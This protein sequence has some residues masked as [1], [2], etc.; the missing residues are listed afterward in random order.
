VPADDSV[1]LAID[2]GADGIEHNAPLRSQDEQ[3]LK[4]MAQKGIS[5]MAGAGAFYIQRIDSTGFIDVIDPAQRRLFPED[6]LSAI[7]DGID[8]LHK[9]TFQ[10]K[11]AGWDAKQRQARFVS[12]MQRAR[13]AGVLLVFG[14]DCG[15]YGAIHGE[16]YK[17]LYGES[18]M[19]SSPM[20]AIVM[21]T[22]DAAKSIGMANELGTIE[23]G[24]LADILVI[25][26]NPLADL[27]NL[28]QVF[29][30]IRSGEVYD[31]AELISERN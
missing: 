23:E 9:Q 13:T 22:R 27:R 29:R 3:T 15:A 16:Q 25:G 17:A 1:K 19:G 7:Y 8:S 20:E 4:L 6:L 21:A 11:S 14:T 12:E 10:M 31:P 24:K 18:R 30:V 28:H 26:A 5:L 2:A